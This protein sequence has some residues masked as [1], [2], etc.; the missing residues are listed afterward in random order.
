VANYA[1]ANHVGDEFVLVP[2]PSEQDRTGTAAAIE[3]GKAV[4]FSSAEID[5]VLRNPG[6][7]EEADDFDVLLRTEASEDRR[8]VLTEVAGSALHFPLLVQRGRRIARLLCRWRSCC[9]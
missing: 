8:S 9:R 5:F 2:V 7:P 6:G 3:F 4:L 1:G